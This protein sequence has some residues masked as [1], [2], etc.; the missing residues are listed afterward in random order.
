M[1]EAAYS[2]AACVVPNTVAYPEIHSGA[3]AMDHLQ[4]ASGLGRLIRATAVS[5]GGRASLPS[6]RGKIRCERNG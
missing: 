5:S 6:E 3:L 2:G 4:I 1:L